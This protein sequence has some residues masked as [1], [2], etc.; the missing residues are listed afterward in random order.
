MWS[1]YRES[2]TVLESAK[3]YRVPDVDL[4]EIL[5]LFQRYKDQK[6]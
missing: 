1:G 3:R 2:S 5:Q 6:K 4:T